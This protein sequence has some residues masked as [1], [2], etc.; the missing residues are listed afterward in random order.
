[1]F[2]QPRQEVLNAPPLTV[3]KELEG[4]VK[5]NLNENPFGPSP[6]VVEKLRTLARNVSRY[7]SPDPQEL[8]QKIAD[9]V[10]VDPENVVVTAGGDE[11]I[12]LLFK[13][14]V[15][16]GD[17]VVITTPT[18]DVYEA[19]AS[20]YGGVPKFA[21]RG[22]GFEILS[23]RVAEQISPKTKAVFVC[24]PNNPTGNATPLSVL[25]ELAELSPLLVVDE[26]YVEFADGSCTS[27]LDGFDNVVVLRTFSKAF[28]LA[29][30]R[31]GYAVACEQIVELMKK[32]K[33]PFN[34]SFLAQQAALAAL[35]D[36][37]Y[38]KWVVDEVRRG[39]DFLYRGLRVLSGVRP[40]QSQANFLL[41]EV[42]GSASELCNRL[43]ER[44]VAVRLLKNRGLPP[45]KFFRVT[46]GLPEE[47]EL[48]L[49]ALE[50]VL[51]S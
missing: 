43:L 37:S 44:G 46:V 17:E 20:L 51:S 16:P 25:K 2:P 23:K 49:E 32:A 26:A 28:G 47:N 50:E 12:D 3:P 48:F 29:G 41:V 35:D 38:V 13:V 36:L 11:A 19:R 22:A 42:E 21:P 6:K 40:Y 31:I 33:L 24:S 45:D 10:G 5:L 39:R 15:N 30:L 18:F 9:Y 4:F 27:L 1:M 34:T 14:F 7:P 8:H